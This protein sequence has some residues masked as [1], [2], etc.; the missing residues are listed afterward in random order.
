MGEHAWGRVERTELMDAVHAALDAGIN[1]FDTADVYGEGV[2]EETL[3]RAL[4]GLRKQAVIATKFGVRLGADRRGFYDNSSAWL[5]QALEGSLRRLGV[6]SIDLYHV[7]YR[8]STTPLDDLIGA[9]ERKRDEG[10]I[11]CFGLSN[12]SAADLALP[13]LHLVGFQAEFSLANR[14]QEALIRA[15]AQ[16]GEMGFMSW[17]SLGQGILTGKYTREVTF[18]DTDRRSR[19]SYGNFRGDRLVRNLRVVEQMRGI[20]SEIGRSIPQ[21]ALRW[22]LDYLPGSVALVGVKRPDQILQNA[23]ALG[24]RLAPEYVELLDRTSKD[25][26]ELTLGSSR[27]LPG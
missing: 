19:E 4:R 13:S 17:G 22:I 7:H 24:W 11:R 15:G 6:D 16:G 18:P 2:S 27:S 12:P 26:E 10:K 9:L 8:D 20:G 25:R 3:G 5:D 14:S 21:I 1:F 23:G